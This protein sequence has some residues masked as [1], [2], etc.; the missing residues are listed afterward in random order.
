M[1]AVHYGLCKQ[2]CVEN[3]SE[4][5]A[6]SELEYISSLCD[7]NELNGNIENIYN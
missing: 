4:L 5:V 1:S 7:Q 6:A 3:A 2:S